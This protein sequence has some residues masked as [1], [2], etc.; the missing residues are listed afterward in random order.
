MQLRI[1]NGKAQIRLTRQEVNQ[2]LAV[3]NILEALAP[4]HKGID[5]N[6]L[7]GLFDYLDTETGVVGAPIAK[8]EPT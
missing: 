2:V 1:K 7:Q 8:G 5:A 3:A 6:G 4:H